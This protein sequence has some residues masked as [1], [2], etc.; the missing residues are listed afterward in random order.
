MSDLED[1]DF[2]EVC[3]GTGHHDSCDS[4]QPAWDVGDLICASPCDGCCP[5]GCKPHGLQKMQDD[6]QLQANGLLGRTRR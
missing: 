3:G 5:L 2:C 4:R 6:A 1:D